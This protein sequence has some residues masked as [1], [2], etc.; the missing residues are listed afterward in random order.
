MNK[1]YKVTAGNS[2]SVWSYY[3]VLSPTAQGAIAKGEKLLKRDHVT[4]DIVISSVQ[5]IAEVD[6]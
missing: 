6:A 2:G 5:L 4:R 3:H 1:I